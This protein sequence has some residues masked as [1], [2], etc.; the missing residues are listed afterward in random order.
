MIACCSEVFAASQS[1][2]DDCWKQELVKIMST[3]AGLASD[4]CY[5]DE[6]ELVEMLV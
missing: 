4:G 2:A 6:T 3:I 5:L 1:S